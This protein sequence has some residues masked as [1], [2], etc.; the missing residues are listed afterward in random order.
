LDLVFVS[1]RLIAEVGVQPDQFA[2]RG[3]QFIGH[4]GWARI[5]TQEHA[6]NGQCI[7]FV[8]FGAQAATL[9]EVMRLGW[10]QEHQT[11]APLLEEIIDLLPIAPRCF[12]PD[13]DVLGGAAELCYLLV[14]ALEPR[15]IIGNNEGCKDHTFVGRERTD[16]TGFAANVES[17]NIV[18]WADS[19]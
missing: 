9:G 11:V 7:Q 2:V 16:H 12:Q 19:T 6:S 17:H 4:I 14:E 8:G 10:M 3:R 1:R 13:D 18:G 15:P 5:L